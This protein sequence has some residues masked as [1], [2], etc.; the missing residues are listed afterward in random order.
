MALL[1]LAAESEDWVNERTLLDFCQAFARELQSDV[2]RPCKRKRLIQ[3]EHNP[4]FKDYYK[5]T[6]CILIV[7]RIC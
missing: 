7:L 5:K 1:V 3:E 2:K 4:F 6:S